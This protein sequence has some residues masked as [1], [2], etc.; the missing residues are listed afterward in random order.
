M[1]TLP[2]GSYQC[3][4]DGMGSAVNP[5]LLSKTKFDTTRTAESYCDNDAANADLH[6]TSRFIANHRTY[7]TRW[8]S[9]TGTMARLSCPQNSRYD[10]NWVDLGLMAR[11]D[12][13][14]PSSKSRALTVPP[15][16]ISRP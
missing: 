13:A 15:F 6:P 9:F 16:V 3:L 11:V 1:P 4:K 14:E 10:L 8:L 5:L 7:T 2:I 12:H